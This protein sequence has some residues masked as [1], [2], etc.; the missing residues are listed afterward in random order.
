MHVPVLLHPR[1]SGLCLAVLF[2]RKLAVFTLQAVGSSYLQLDK[3]YEHYL[4]HTAAN[5]AIGGFGGI[6]G[7]DYICVQSYDGQLSFF[8]Q[9]AFAFSRFLPN[10][11][12]PG[13]LC[14]CAPSD[15]FITCNAAFEL[16][17]YKYSVLAAASGEKDTAPAAGSAAAAAAVP[18]GKKIQV[19]WS[20]ILGEAAVDIRVGRVTEGVKAEYQADLLVLC[21]HTFFVLSLRGQLLMQRRL[22]YHPACCWPYASAFTAGNK[23]SRLD[24][25][26]VATHT[27]ALLVY[28]GATL[29]WAAKLET[30]PVAVRVAQIGATK[31]MIITLDDTGALSV[32]YLGTE[33]PIHAISYGDA[34]EVDYAAM[35][36]EHKQLMTKIKQA[37]SAPA[38]TD[39]A[40]KLIIK[41][42]VPSRLDTGS[43]GIDDL[44]DGAGAMF[45]RSGGAGSTTRR[46][47]IKLYLTHAGP[48]TLQDV[49]LTI[50]APSPITVSEPQLVIPEVPSSSAR[51]CEPAVVTVVLAA[52]SS[53]LP[54]TDTVQVVATYRNQAGEPRCASLSMNL[55]LCLFCQV[56]PPIKT[57]EHKI[58]LGTI[59][60]P[61][62]LVQIFQDLMVQ[63]S[64]AHAEA[65]S[66]SQ[67]A[68]VL[69]FQYYSGQEV[70]I[71]VSKNAG[72]YRIQADCFQAMWLIT[73]ELCRRLSSYY[74]SSHG[75]PNQP[76]DQSALTITFEE[77]LPLQEFFDVVEQHFIARLSISK[78][79]EQLE[80]R[81]Q[82]FRSIQKRL[83]VRFK[84]KTPAPLNQLDVVMDETYHQLVSL[85]D[86]MEKAQAKVS[87]AGQALGA[88]VQLMLQLIR[89]RFA[90]SAED[91]EV[92][93][94]ALTPV[95]EEG[96]EV[97]WEETTE[98][99]MTHLLRSSLARSAKES[100]AVV[101]PLVTAKD[102]Q[103]LRKHVSL[104]L[105]RLGKGM[106][107]T[108]SGAQRGDTAMMTD[109]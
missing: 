44:E 75:K 93:Q 101:P 79:S 21:E 45:G 30:Q 54:A 63:A 98:A 43:G 86:D 105:E 23:P 109:A 59:K 47:T 94:C 33:P 15:S 11:L 70:T 58:T 66:R 37:G 77:Q 5:M 50:T 7:A 32:V 18:A 28:Q 64:P 53:S 92:L 60:D 106:K 82:Q 38:P 95:V 25:L 102:T 3:L 35:D 51:T 74:A 39:T 76:Q 31:G 71:V 55:P 1:G 100:A 52:G 65:L 68:N 2:P 27:K 78:L 84:D 85:A 26:L 72:R 104:V 97:G 89:Y 16:E 22:D 14:Y 99:A 41:A 36:A 61:P 10:F 6:S 48:G 56:V 83:L 20:I 88:A 19:D 96:P 57:A 17:S 62:Q 80:E 108:G 34:K 69:S 12:I 91:V 81:A 107:L 90:L 87:E 42:Q 8:E 73:Q 49:S 24:N 13:P 40:D 9:E 103:R 46:L 29:S 67:A 4:D